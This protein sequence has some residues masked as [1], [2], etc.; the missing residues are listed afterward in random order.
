MLRKMASLA[1]LGMDL[2]GNSNGG[3]DTG[4]MPSSSGGL[5]GSNLMDDILSEMEQTD[6]HVTPS[7]GGG[8][9]GGSSPGMFESS[10]QQPN[11]NDMRDMM[12]QQQQQQMYQQQLADQARQL[13]QMQQPM[14]ASMGPMSYGEAGMIRMAIEEAKKPLVV[15]GVTLAMSLPFVNSLLAKYVP[16]F[17]TKTGSISMIGLFIRALL[18]GLVFYFVN[19][20]TDKYL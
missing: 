19:K 10:P 5:Q 18:I 9:G 17:V 11:S 12:A 2:G 4:V 20:A 7:G 14:P 15:T 8:G 3:M 16:R 1:E 13:Q 6:H